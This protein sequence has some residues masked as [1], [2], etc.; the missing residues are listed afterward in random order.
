M[1]RQLD[2]QMPKKE[3][4]PLHTSHHI[5]N[6]CDLR[7]GNSTLRHQKYKQQKKKTNK[8]QLYQNWN[9]YA[10]KDTKKVK[11]KPTEWEKFL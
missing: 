7:L 4:G 1:L 3:A 11:R 8:M 10:T 5:L 9:V 2:I 6:L